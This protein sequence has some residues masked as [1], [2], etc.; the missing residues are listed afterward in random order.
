VL[1]VDLDTAVRDKLV[2]NARKYPP[3]GQRTAHDYG[4]V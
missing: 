3:P 1:G 4:T 2:Q